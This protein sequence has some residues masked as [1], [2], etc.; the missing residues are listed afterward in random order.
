MTMDIGSETQLPSRNDF[1]QDWNT[2][3]EA[4]VG[5]ES[6][7]EWL[8]WGAEDEKFPC[9]DSPFKQYASLNFTANTIFLI[10]VLDLV[11]LIYVHL[12]AHWWVY[13]HLTKLSIN[14]M[15]TTVLGHC[16]NRPTP[17]SSPSPRAQV[18]GVIRRK[19]HAKTQICTE[20][21]PGSSYRL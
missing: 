14:S 8:V 21:L 1:G 7:R 9:Q 3:M 5:P 12:D 15:I 16:L 11:L 17:H 13:M 19:S 10:P 2:L 18:E 20:V 4:V 6:W